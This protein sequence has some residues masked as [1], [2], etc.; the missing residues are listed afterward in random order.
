MALTIREQILQTLAT[1]TTAD[2]GLEMYDERDLPATFLIEGEEQAGEDEYDNTHVSLSVTLAR[3]I[4]LVGN[5][6]DDWYEEANTALGNLVKEV[7]VGGEDLGGLADG[8][9]YEGAGVSIITD[10]ARGAMVQV[11]FGIRFAFL[12]GDPFTQ[13]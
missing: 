8:I 11:S 13:Q 6:G 10:G 4:P 1:R 5:K 12:H 3:A 2:R 7:Y 9:D